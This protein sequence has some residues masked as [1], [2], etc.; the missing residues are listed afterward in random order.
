[1]LHSEK[2]VEL[3]SLNRESFVLSNCEEDDQTSVILPNESYVE[4]EMSYEGL[5][6]PT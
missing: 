2:E 6:T 5:L 4:I 1:M 3:Q